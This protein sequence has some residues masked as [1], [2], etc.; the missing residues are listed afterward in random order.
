MTTGKNITIPA[1]RI[2]S[3]VMLCTCFVETAYTRLNQ[4]SRPPALIAVPVI[5]IYIFFVVAYKD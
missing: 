2:E 5:E 1:H 4:H 3:T